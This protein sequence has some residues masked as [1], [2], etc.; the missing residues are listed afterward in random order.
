MT[1]PL[2]LVIEDEVDLAEIFAEAVRAGGFAPETIHHG[3]AARQRLQEVIPEIV[4]LDLHLPGVDGAQLLDQIC[5]D[6]R[7]QA[8]KV[9]VTTA[10]HNLA[11]SLRGKATLVMLK[12]VSFTQLRDLSTRL[13][14]LVIEAD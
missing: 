8:T 9:I 10:D 5:A 13:K 6:P 7:L 4:V 3:G 14:G 2:A 1:D 11:D 12:P